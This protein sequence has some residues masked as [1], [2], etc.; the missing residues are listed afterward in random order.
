MK[1]RNNF[2]LLILYI[3]GLSIILRE[4]LW[5]PIVAALVLFIVDGKIPDHLRE[6]AYLATAFTVSLPFLAIVAFYLPFMGFGMALSNTS[7][8]KRY[9]LG[10]AAA[11]F[12]TLLLYTSL[13]VGSY[14]MTPLMATILMSIPPLGCLAYLWHRGK[15]GGA[16][17]L[18]A[19]QMRVLLLCL[20]ALFWVG[21]GILNDQSLFM[22]NGTWFYSKYDAIV[23]GIRENGEFPTYWPNSAQGEHLFL[24]DAPGFFSH[25]GF[26]NLS[27]PWIPT[28]L[29]F[30][31]YSLFL[32]FLTMM[33]VALVLQ[34][35]V[36]ATSKLSPYIWALCTIVAVLNFVFIQFLESVKQFFVHPIG[37]LILA[38]IIGQPKRIEEFIIIGAC[39]ALMVTLHPAQSIGTLLM[40]FC[41][42]IGMQFMPGSLV[43]QRG[44]FL[45]QLKE[46]RWVVVGL[47]LIVVALPL[48]YVLP[49]MEYKSMMRQ[50]S[51]EI[52]SYLPNAGDYIQGFVSQNPLSWHNPDV[53]RIDD[54][55][56]GPFLSVFG[57]IA[58]V[59]T[60]LLWKR[61]SLRKVNVFIAA[62]GAYVLVSSIVVNF[63]FINNVE[64]GYRTLTPY[65]MIMLVVAIAE[66]CAQLG[67]WVAVAGMG[68]LSFG[69]I[70]TLPLVE[71][72]LNNIH[73]ESMI[74]GQNYREEIE[75]IKTLPIDGRIMTY[76]YYGN[77]VDP[78]MAILTGKYFSRY[79]F[80]QFDTSKKLY[81]EIH[82]SH[83]WGDPEYVQRFSDVELA[84]KL[85]IGG[86]KY[87]FINVCYPTGQ[88][89][90][91]KMYPNHSTAIYQNQCNVILILNQTAYAEKVNMVSDEEIK[92][93]V[94]EEGGFVFQAI[95]NEYPWYQYDGG[96]TQ[97]VKA[98]SPVE[99]K[100]LSAGKIE[101]HGDFKEGEWVVFKEQYSP[102]W[103]ALME[104]MPLEVM[105]TTHYLIAIKAGSGKTIVL[106]DVPLPIER[107]AAGI[108]LVAILGFL[109]AL[110]LLITRANGSNL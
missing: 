84:N 93:R 24:A 36:S 11:I 10:F 27:M 105:S 43:E 88:I 69:L 87:L 31:T 103:K 82:S 4:I 100:R 55:R 18:D 63:P 107:I 7:F 5:V 28:V 39:L 33:G 86:Y 23:A 51:I 6:T 52:G 91:T 75:F 67:R 81:E 92:Q 14:A 30:N 76:G 72:N 101:L 79:E 40:A 46:G 89:V 60:L 106:E 85:R 44:Q 59:L 32:L 61:D 64:Y 34:E 20:F 38:I 21:H 108:S 54:K 37:L 50:G 58:M 65:M 99:F 41:L 26:L 77:A 22:S 96:K 1:I 9:L 15:I 102:R 71:Q 19:V 68:A 16:F 25:L 90:A 3:L 83:S 57:V 70:M 48:F 47:I 12:T 98:F 49:L 42:F 110:C 94:K 97:N 29:F 78:G 53:R 109:G 80:K 17:V 74:S 45:Q 13:I 62:F 104:N 56:I 66:L 8:I 35:L 73:G 95:T 2:V